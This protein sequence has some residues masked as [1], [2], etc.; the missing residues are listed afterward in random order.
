MRF[1]LHHTT[2]ESW[3][4]MLAAL[5][6]AKVSID[7]EHFIF[8]EEGVGEE[9]LKVLCRK[10]GEGVRVRLLLD[11]VGSNELTSRALA[12]RCSKN[13]IELRF[14]NTIVP[15]S[16]GHHTPIFFRDHQKLIVID[17]HLGITGGVCIEER[18]RGWRDTALFIEDKGVVAEMQGSFDYMWARARKEKLS[19]PRRD[20]NRESRYLRDTPLSRKRPAYRALRAR[21]RLARKSIMLTTPYF[22]PPHRLVRLLKNAALRGVA[23]SLVVPERSD[24]LLA[25]IAGQSYFSNLLKAGVCIY[26][27]GKPTLH[28]KYAVVD[29]AWSMLGSHNLDHLS[30]QYNFEGSVLSN[31]P[32][33]AEALEA[34]ARIDIA[35][36]T[37]ITKESWQ[38]RPLTE[39]ILEIL[40]WPVSF[41]L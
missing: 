22:V 33:L 2:T 19:L 40:V 18:M 16:V 14:F 28:A 12:E 5:E 30:L 15:L 38:K 4:A 39:K 29:S 35:Q 21:L 41:F 23:V 34:Q 36:A 10:A 8:K 25:D 6:H 7:L 17:G 31:D 24:A 32:L 26:R 3:A 1:T 20:G 11:A 27:Y 9:F 13:R 37:E